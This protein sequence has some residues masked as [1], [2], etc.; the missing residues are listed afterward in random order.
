[1]LV[2]THWKN[3]TGK[4]YFLYDISQKIKMHCFIRELQKA[5]HWPVKN[6]TGILLY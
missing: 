6:D 2:H 3:V 1:M 4:K 5:L